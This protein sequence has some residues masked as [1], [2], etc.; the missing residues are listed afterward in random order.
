MREVRELAT[1]LLDRGQLIP[2]LA[3]LRFAV[4]PVL[5]SGCCTLC[6]VLIL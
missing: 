6:S 3:S 1:D 4:Y 2:G 5:R